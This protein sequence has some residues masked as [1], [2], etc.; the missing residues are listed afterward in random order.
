M[1]D[2]HQLSFSSWV[3]MLCFLICQHSYSNTNCRQVCIR[4]EKYFLS[5]I[6]FGYKILFRTLWGTKNKKGWKKTVSW[7]FNPAWKAMKQQH[8][9]HL[10]FLLVVI[11]AC[12]CGCWALKISRAVPCTLAF[13]QAEF[14][15]RQRTAPTSPL[16]EQKKA[17]GVTIAWD[18]WWAWMV[19]G[20]YFFQSQADPKPLKIHDLKD[21]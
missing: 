14:F 2:F 5:S 9:L 13:L 18:I 8:C 7:G 3:V 1:P 16:I 17:A 11:K 20:D 6:M 15:V 12:S 21:E 10:S 4:V 19:P